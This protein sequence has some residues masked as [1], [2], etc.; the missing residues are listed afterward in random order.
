MFENKHILI[1]PLNWGIG[2]AT[3]MVAYAKRLEKDG[4]IITVMGATQV[5]DVFKEEMPH[6]KCIPF[7]DIKVHYAHS[8]KIVR[9]LVFYLP[10]FLWSAVKEHYALRRL[11]KK[12]NFDVVISDN[13]PALWSNKVKSYYI[14]HQL[15]IKLSKG[16]HWAERFSNVV[17]QWFISHYEA[18]LIPDVQGE[19][20]LAGELSRYKHPR[21]AVKYIGWLSRFTPPDVWPG[22]ENYTLLVLSGVEPHRSFFRD[23]IVKRYKNTDEQL[24]IAGDDRAV[25][26]E[27]IISLPYVRTEAL[28]P[29][30]LSAKHVICR[31]G[32][33]MLMDLKVLGC[34]AE[35]IPTP[36]QPEQ[37]Y[38]AK[39]HAK[40]V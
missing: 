27:N 31:S 13:R 1:C 30:I 9:K 5:L 15:S 29:L 33:S 26:I 21:I 11:L 32:Y 2:H 28:K 8:N 35:L 10:V 34:D 12:H 20:A 6:V 22:K 40:E 18:C 3:R 14:T 23:E 37:E 7:I 36:G 4:N 38:L 19:N 24:I 16:W 25:T 39:L 17:H